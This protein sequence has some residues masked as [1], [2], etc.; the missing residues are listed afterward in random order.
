VDLLRKDRLSRPRRPEHKD[1]KVRRGELFQQIADAVFKKNFVRHGN[2]FAALAAKK[3]VF[4]L[5]VQSAFERQPRKGACLACVALPPVN[6]RTSSFVHISAVPLHS[7]DMNANFRATSL[8]L[9]VP[10]LFSSL[11]LIGCAASSKPPR[12][13]TDPAEILRWTIGPPYLPAPPSP[14]VSLILIPKNKLKPAPKPSPSAPK[15]VA[16]DLS[17]NDY[18]VVSECIRARSFLPTSW[19]D[20][21]LLCDDGIVHVFDRNTKKSTPVGGLTPAINIERLLAYR[22][23]NET[24][25]VLVSGTSQGE[26]KPEIYSLIVDATGITRWSLA[27]L[28]FNDASEYYRA[29]VAPRCS[30]DGKTCLRI[31]SDDVT[32]NVEQWSATG[33][34][35]AV[36]LEPSVKGAADIAWAPINDGSIY[37]LK[38][39]ENNA[40]SYP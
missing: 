2:V 34:G 13:R 26:N 17:P 18:E 35:T 28:S 33:A 29:F 27:E 40:K 31:S 32:E 30:P 7:A 20:R 21:I 25:E 39:C 9:L 11:L 12:A 37:L 36:M 10:F 4:L 15:P 24:L 3:V 6:F 5:G 1:R 19:S 8:L 23:I 22:K 16:T 14:D 38:H